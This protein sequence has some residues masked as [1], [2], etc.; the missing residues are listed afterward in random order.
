M[1]AGTALPQRMPAQGSVLE[2]ALQA[3]SATDL[4]H[5]GSLPQTDNGRQCETLTYVIDL[6]HMSSRGIGKSLL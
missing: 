6:I 3:V 5:P 4:V 2:E 1:L